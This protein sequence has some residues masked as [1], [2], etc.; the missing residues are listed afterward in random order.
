VLGGWLD[1]RWWAVLPD[2]SLPSL[3]LQQEGT[4]RYALRALPPLFP[5]RPTRSPGARLQ[6]RAQGLQRPQRSLR[7][8]QIKIN[9][10]KKQ[11]STA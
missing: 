4:F 6:G 11:K 9:L 2:L 7:I 10:E 5:L 1:H 8:K 3:P